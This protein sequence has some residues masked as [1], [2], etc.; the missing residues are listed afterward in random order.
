MQRDTFPVNCKIHEYFF[1]FDFN[2]HRKGGEMRDTETL[3][4]SR[5][6]VSLQVLGRCFEFFTLR[7]QLVAG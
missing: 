7:D 2:Q 6:V 3:N 1:F 4:L 5:N